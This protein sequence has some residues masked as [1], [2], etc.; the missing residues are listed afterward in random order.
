MG[1][2][3]NDTL[4]RATY[5][6]QTADSG[7]I[8]TGN[9]TV[10]LK[11]DGSIAWIDNIAASV[12][13]QSPDGGY[14]FCN[15]SYNYSAPGLTKLNPDGSIAWQKNYNTSTFA[16]QY[17]I[18]DVCL[19]SNNG[20]IVA[21]IVY[22]IYNS[23]FITATDDSGNFIIPVV[24][25]FSHG[26]G[27]L[28]C[29]EKKGNSYLN[30][31]QISSSGTHLS[32]VNDSCVADWTDGINNISLS[33]IAGTNQ[34]GALGCGSTTYTIPDVAVVSYDSN[35]NFQWE[36]DMGGS[37]KDYGNSVFQAANGNYL[38]AG[39]T[40]SNDGDVSG[41]HGGGDGWIV[42]FGT[43]VGVP[44]VN[45]NKDE[46][47]TYPVPAGDYVH[48]DLPAGFQNA[49]LILVDVSGRT[50]PAYQ[51]NNGASRVLNLD[52]LPPGAYLLQVI[53]NGD[54]YT[55]KILHY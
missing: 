19:S 2:T 31:T 8:L 14:I 15:N 6:E 44:V 33:A 54:Y 27:R 16:D 37:Q 30:V 18:F 39:V 22:D 32:K 11:N 29:N 51:E 42:A 49:T 36:K 46:I 38:V 23:P 55:R 3:Y 34:N 4:S 47:K 12:I 53:N 48:V 21:G 40:N 20:Y 1:K 17:L 7:Y 50:V 28:V 10:K 5:I 24:N 43:N 13:H 52:G 9:Q 26:T 25:N 41:N 45:G 35:G